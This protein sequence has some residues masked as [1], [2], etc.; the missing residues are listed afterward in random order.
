MLD[1]NCR[2]Q[3]WIGGETHYD[4]ILTRWVFLLATGVSRS[5]RLIGPLPLISAVIGQWSEEFLLT[6][7]DT[8]PPTKHY[9]TL[10]QHNNKSKYFRLRLSY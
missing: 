7:S 1:W 8:T 5:W 2:V 3:K 4:L 6:P 10:L 9:D